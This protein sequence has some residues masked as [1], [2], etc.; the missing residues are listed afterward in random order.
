MLSFDGER[1][2]PLYKCS[3]LRFIHIANNALT[4]IFSDWKELRS[5]ETLDV[6][7][8]KITQIQVITITYHI[9]VEIMIFIIVGI[10]YVIQYLQTYHS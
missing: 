4:K 5:L 10:P 1:V 7:H 8:N 9:T 6:K 2:S 3:N